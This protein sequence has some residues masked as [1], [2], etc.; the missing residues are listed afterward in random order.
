MRTT[1]T[2]CTAGLGG[3]G[4]LGGAI[5][6]GADLAIIAPTW[7]GMVCTLAAQSGSSMSQHTAKKL[8]MAVATGC[9]TFVVGTKIASTVFAW[10]LA[11]PTAGMSVAANMAAN[12]GLNA[13]LTHAFGTATARFFL[14]TSS[15][16]N[17]D[18]AIQVI[19][20]LVGLEFGIPTSRDDVI[21]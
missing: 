2:T 11:L 1:I 19:I 16:D 14:Q 6:P 4:I 12:A 21:A 18:L 13:K 3:V 20:A 10:V 9:G 8:A 5:G 17:T 15:I 7:V